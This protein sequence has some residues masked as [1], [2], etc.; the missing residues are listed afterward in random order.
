MEQ[1][2]HINGTLVR[3]EDARISVFDHGLLY[4]NGLFET[5]RAYQGR[6]FRL[7]HH[8]QRLFRS[9]EFL[10]Y[11]V[12]FTPA[13]L[14]RSVYETVEANQT[15]DASIR[16]NVTRGQGDPVPNPDTCGQPTIII[17]AREYQPPSPAL[18]NQ[19][20]SATIL[21]YRQSPRLPATLVKTFSFINT[22]IARMEAKSSGCHEGIMVNTDGFIA[23]CTVSNIFMIRGSRLQTPSL[24]SGLLPG[25]TRQAVLELAA[26][27]RMQPEEGTF[28]PEQ[29]RTADEAFVTNSLIEIMPLV[30]V[31]GHEIGNGTPGAA[32]QTL[33]AAYKELVRRELKL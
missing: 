15:P 4:G 28:T 7:E 22:I 19:G 2:V 11:P 23:E 17:F 12:S 1:Y 33:M 31:D 10:K 21:P 18:Y 6:I 27:R 30:T 25:V 16:L 20:F 24:Q 3:R 8:L 29:L 14:E 5:M 13:S 9:L 26:G 32:T